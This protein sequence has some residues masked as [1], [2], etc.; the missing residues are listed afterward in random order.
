MSGKNCFIDFIHMESLKENI[1]FF[2]M[3]AIIKQIRVWQDASNQ[4]Q[5]KTEDFL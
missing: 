1:V 4:N 2:N 5:T 3:Y